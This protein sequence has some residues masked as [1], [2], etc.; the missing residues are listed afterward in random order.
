MEEPPVL[1]KHLVV[2]FISTVRAQRQEAKR[3]QEHEKVRTWQD[4][5]EIRK[6]VPAS[7]GGRQ[8]TRVWLKQEHTEGFADPPWF[9]RWEV[10]ATRE[11]VQEPKQPKERSG[12][13]FEVW[14]P[15]VSASTAPWDSR[16]RGPLL[17]TMLALLLGAV[18][19][20]ASHSRIY[21]YGPKACE[22]TEP[23]CRC[24]RNDALNE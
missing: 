4:R 21:D 7:H 10:P 5:G 20:L 17:P 15:F 18:Y 13:R 3:W 23:I 12:L 6:K 11:S 2:F 9:S 24:A 1:P 19:S 16:T 22:P 14:F 8:R